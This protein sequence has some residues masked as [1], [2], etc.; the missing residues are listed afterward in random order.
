MKYV[1]VIE[2][3]SQ[4]NP[5]FGVIIPDLPGCYSQGD[6]LDEAIKNAHEAACL[7][8]DTALDEG[9]QLPHASTFSELQKGHPE[10]AGW[11]WSVVDIDLGK[12]GD[13]AE[14]IYITIPRRILRRLDTL[15]QKSGDT[16]SGYIARMVMQAAL[17]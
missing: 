16:R 15:A 4:E 17:G 9:M 5:D 12:V 1:I 13:K 11:L 8:I 7:W 14:R 2:P 10:W 6:D 3:D